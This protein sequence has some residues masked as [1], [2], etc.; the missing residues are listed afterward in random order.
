MINR[1]EKG[2]D[3]VGYRM[4]WESGKQEKLLILDKGVKMLMGIEKQS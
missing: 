3:R 4:G 2:R 1:G